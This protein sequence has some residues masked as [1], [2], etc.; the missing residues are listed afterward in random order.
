MQELGRMI[1][2]RDEVEVEVLNAVFVQDILGAN[3]LAQVQ[4]AQDACLC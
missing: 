3:Q 2:E 4:V 1:I